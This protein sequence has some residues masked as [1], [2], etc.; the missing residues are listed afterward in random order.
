MPGGDRL[1]LEVKEP[2]AQNGTSSSDVN[3]GRTGQP[4]CHGLENARTL[5]VPFEILMG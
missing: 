4:V 1:E 5:L 3:R 2:S